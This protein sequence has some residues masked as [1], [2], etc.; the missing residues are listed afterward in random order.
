MAERTAPPA[1]KLS[2]ASGALNQ[3]AI[4]PVYVIGHLNPDTDAIASA[5]GYAWLLRERYRL[6]LER[7]RVAGQQSSGERG[8]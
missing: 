8:V 2:A 6:A 7:E 5:M 4:T 3:A 1:H